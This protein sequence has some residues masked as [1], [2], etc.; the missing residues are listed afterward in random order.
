MTCRN[1][2][3]DVASGEAGGCEFHMYWIQ[4]A[5]AK[6]IV[7]NKCAIVVCLVIIECILFLI[8]VDSSGVS[9]PVFG[10]CGF[11]ERSAGEHV[12]IAESLA[13]FI[14]HGKF[15]GHL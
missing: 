2:G 5:C 7:N 12:V 3:S 15:L 4:R 13:V 10:K 6:Q 1:V 9:I 11:A 8:F 14:F